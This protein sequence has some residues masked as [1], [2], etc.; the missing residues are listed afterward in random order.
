[1][2]EIFGWVPWFRELGQRIAE[3][4]ERYLIDKAKTVA[5][6]DGDGQSPLLN[7]GDEN[8]DPFSFYF[9]LASLSRSSRSRNRIYPGIANAFELTGTLPLDSNDAFIFPTPP[10]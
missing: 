7:Y 9:T 5:W 3:G 6:K 8:I 1:M 2:K 10:G 4:G